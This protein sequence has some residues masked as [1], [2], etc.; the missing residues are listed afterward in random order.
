M[1]LRSSR[2][3]ENFFDLF[4][5]DEA[6]LYPVRRELGQPFSYSCLVVDDQQ[7]LW[8]PINLQTPWF[9]DSHF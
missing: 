9:I 6:I 2:G 5:L 4:I 1:G 3:I 8:I 7:G